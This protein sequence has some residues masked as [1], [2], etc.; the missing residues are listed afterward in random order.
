MAGG[1]C[2]LISALEDEWRDALCAKDMGR[3]RS[4]IHPKFVLIGTR[5]SG[6][7]TMTRDEWIDA[8]QKREPLSVELSIEDAVVL[9][10][11]M[12]GT[13]HARWRIQYLG[14]QI[15]DCVL[16][17]DVW[18]FDEERWRVVRRH[19]TPAPPQG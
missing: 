1:S 6:P 4:L 16:L 18:V 15:E 17:T 3:L 10:K 2:E 7:F 9:D 13:I 19:S 11:V 14:R 12:V 5:A 8:I